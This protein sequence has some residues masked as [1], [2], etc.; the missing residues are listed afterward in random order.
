MCKEEFLSLQ[1]DQHVDLQHGFILL[2]KTK[3]GERREIPIDAVLRQTLRGI[4]RRVDSPYVFR[5]PGEEIAGRQA[6]VSGCL[7]TGRQHCL[8]SKRA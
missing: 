5:C 2:D 4:M 3:S 8:H 7:S 1:W 6:R